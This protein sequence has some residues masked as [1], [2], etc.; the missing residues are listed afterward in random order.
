MNDVLLVHVLQ[1]LADLTH[2]ANHLGLGHLVVLVGDLVEQLAARQTAYRRTRTHCRSA[3]GDR[4]S[5]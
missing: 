2:V 3:R 1:S 5:G 4:V